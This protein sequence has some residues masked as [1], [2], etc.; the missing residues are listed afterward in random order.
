MTQAAQVRLGG[1]RPAAVNPL[2][3]LWSAFLALGMVFSLTPQ[4]RWGSADLGPGELLISLWLLRGLAILL[5]GFRSDVTRPLRE[6]AVFWAIFA[7]ALC[8]GA[9]ETIGSAFLDDWSLVLHDIMAYLLLVV[10]MG[11]QFALPG[12]AR[13]VHVIQWVTALFGAL[14]LALQMTNALGVFTLSNIDPW[15]WDRLRGWCDNPNQF[16]LLAM[17]IGFLA[18]ELAERD[19]GLIPKLAASVCASIALGIGWLGQSNAYSG[20]VFATFG[21]FGLLKVVRAAIYAERR[22]FPG[23]A[24]C[25]ATLASLAFISCLF[26]PAIESLVEARGGPLSLIARRGED[27]DG[28][29]KLRLYLWKETIERGLDSWMLGFG[30]GPHL[31]IPNSLTESHRSA[32]EPINLT[33]PKV[34]LA[35]NY[36]AHNTFLE[37]FVQGGIL[38]V[39]SFVWI[40]A[41]AIGRAWKAG[42]DGLIALLFAIAAFGS[43]H[44]VFRHPIVWF[45]IGLALQAE[46]GF[47]ERAAVTSSRNL[48]AGQQSIFRAA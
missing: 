26:E 30:P 3:L 2:E 25:A 22:G 15:Y 6:L 36:E 17:V 29:A 45:A 33:H 1:P 5:I 19:V 24:L 39:G 14:Y 27:Q 48:R 13:R 31:D 10:L 23:I 7:A 44:V 12:A 38:A 11:V 46:Q 42:L 37:L 8:L 9:T 21:L 34:G 41:L 16:A 35:P 47:R 28:E 32:G 4:L 40:G 18:L 20:V 43:F